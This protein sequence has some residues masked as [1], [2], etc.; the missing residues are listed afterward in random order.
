MTRQ[1]I[2]SELRAYRENAARMG[3]LTERAAMLERDILAARTALVEDPSGVGAQ[4]L[5]G[6]PGAKAG[7]SVVERMAML[8]IEDPPEVYDMTRELIKVQAETEKLGHRVAMVE[9]WLSAL[10][11]R[12]RY[13]VM[14]YYFD[15]LT[16]AGVCERYMLRYRGVTLSEVHAKRVRGI[17]LDK[18]ARVMNAPESQNDTKMI[19]K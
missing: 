12:E 1:Q 15:G 5:D 3:V 2:E 14:L 18:I 7:A 16:W 9:R 8:G 19:R 4:R 13:I 17:A 6:M 10:E 11:E